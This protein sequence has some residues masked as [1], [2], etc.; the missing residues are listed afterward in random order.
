MSLRR[1]S[2]ALV[3]C[4][5]SLV[6]PS[7]AGENWPNWRGPQNNGVGTETELPATWSTSEN[8]AWK[9]PL[10][11]QAGATPV[12]WGDR[13]FIPAVDGDNLVLICAETEKGQ[14]LWRKT[15]GVG[16]KQYMSGEG[17]SASPSPSTDG[18]Q[19]WVFMGNG[20]LVCYDFAG[21]ETWRTNIEERYGKFDIQFGMTSTPVLDGDRLYLQL[22]HTGSKKL[23]ALDK[24]TGDEIW[25]HE[26]QSDAYAENEH[27][28]TSPMIYRDNERAFLVV[29]GADF[30]TGHRLTDGSE[31]WRC[32]G[33]NPQGSDYNEY[34]RFVASPAMEPGLIVVPTAKNGPVLAIRPDAEG[35]VTENDK[36]RAWT[37][38]NSTPD[39]PSPVIHDGLVYLCNE[40]GVLLC[41]DAE[42]GEQ[43]YKERLHSDVYRASPVIA[44]GKFYVVSRDG[45]VSVVE[46]GPKF[47]KLAENKMGEPVSASP[48]LA[49][50]TIYLRTYDHLYAIR[51]AK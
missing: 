33:I 35:N 46:V 32:G 41:L 19:I 20:D 29:H 7:F 50:G 2:L 40:K 51:E 15:V 4:L 44:A 38:P 25:V 3:L 8:V 13:I 39:V 6:L 28:Y 48:V 45:T 31:I 30:V 9:L 34:L 36:Y 11:G 43:L 22:L 14:E 49:D 42:T 12:V 27:A 21:E 5:A 17:N 18:E 10:P 23:V 24:K 47:K 16:N 1:V 26:R 37:F